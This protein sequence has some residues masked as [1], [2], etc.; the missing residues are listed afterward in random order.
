MIY[1]SLYVGFPKLGSFCKTGFLVLGK[2]KTGFRFLVWKSHR[3]NCVHCKS[4]GVEIKDGADR[5]VCSAGNVHVAT[6]D[7]GV[8]C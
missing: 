6:S 4:A 7:R 1:L 5:T 2:A 3:P 8:R